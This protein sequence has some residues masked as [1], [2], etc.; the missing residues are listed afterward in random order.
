[1]S[2]KFEPGALV[3]LLRAENKHCKPLVGTFQTIKTK[4]ALSANYWL[5]DGVFAGPRNFQ[6]S[7]NG[8]D[9]KLINPGSGNE[10]WFK[11]APLT[12]KPKQPEADHV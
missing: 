11:A 12:E 8:D 7:W 6:V 3:I 5:L 2:G 9:M 10:S 1:M 4:E